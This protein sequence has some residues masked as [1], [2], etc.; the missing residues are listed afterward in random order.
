MARIWQPLWTYAGVPTHTKSLRDA[1]LTTRLASVGQ[2]SARLLY[3]EHKPV[4]TLPRIASGAFREALA[5]PLRLESLSGTDW[6]RDRPAGS[7]ALDL[8][9]PPAVAIHP[10]HVATDG[11]AVIG[12]VCPG[13]AEQLPAAES[14]SA[15]LPSRSATFDGLRLT[16][17]GRRAMSVSAC[18]CYHDCY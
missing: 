13:Q 2:V 1:P 5:G 10:A 15:V 4:A 18:R 12:R 16:L 8:S 14:A 9:E 7:G 3:G 6:E 17:G 11:Q